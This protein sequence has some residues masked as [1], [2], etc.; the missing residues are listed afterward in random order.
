MNVCTFIV[1]DMPTFKVS[2]TRLLLHDECIETLHYY[3]LVTTALC[4][5]TSKGS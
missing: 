4:S 2:F 1:I 3:T 5:L